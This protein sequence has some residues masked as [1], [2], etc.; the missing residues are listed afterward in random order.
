MVLV[1]Y[2]NPAQI[3][4]AGTYYIKATNPGGCSLVKPVTVRFNPS[5]SLVITNPPATCAPAVVDLTKPAITAGSGAGLTYTY[6]TNVLGTITLP[7]PQAVSAAGTYYIKAA[8]NGCTVI[9]P[10]QVI[11]TTPPVL[12]VTNPAAVCAP[13][14]VDITR[15]VCYCWQR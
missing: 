5:P 15:P 12:V 3:A 9:K 13:E 8:S 2:P 10:V 11:S 7:N 14:T 6:W 4:T 1:L